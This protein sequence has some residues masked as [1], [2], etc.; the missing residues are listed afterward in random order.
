MV[1]FDFNKT[2]N[3]ITKEGDIFTIIK[4]VLLI[5]SIMAALITI[6]YFIIDYFLF[7]LTVITFL[8]IIT[9]CILIS[10]FRLRT[11]S[12]NLLI[13]YIDKDKNHKVLA[14][15]FDKRSDE[16]NI[17]KN[18]LKSIETILIIMVT[19]SKLKERKELFNLYLNIKHTM[20]GNANDRE[21][22]SYKDS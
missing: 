6:A 4:R 19:K 2:R 10:F 18:Q 17:T 1:N 3:G 16:L 12:K 14:K 21:V 15:L 20:G 7:Y 13:H 22:E 9:I 5:L 11:Y 8:I